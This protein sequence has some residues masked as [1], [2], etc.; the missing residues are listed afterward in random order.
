MSQ[1]KSE[2]ILSPNLST[3]NKAHASAMKL[4][5]TLI[6]LRK[7]IRDLDAAIRNISKN[8]IDAT[9]FFEH[10]KWFSKIPLKLSAELT[11]LIKPYFI[12]SINWNTETSTYKHPGSKKGHHPDTITYDV[13]TI[14]FKGILRNYT[15]NIPTDIYKNGKRP[16]SPYEAS[17]IIFDFFT[18]KNNPPNPTD[19]ELEQA[20]QELIKKIEKEKASLYKKEQ[21]LMKNKKEILHQLNKNIKQNL[22]NH[23]KG[24]SILEEKQKESIHYNPTGDEIVLDKDIFK[25][26]YLLV[27][28]KVAT[29]SS[30]KKWYTGLITKYD[31]STKKYTVEYDDGN[32]LN[33]DFTKTQF[34]ITDTTIIE[35]LNKL[36]RLE[37]EIDGCR[38]LVKSLSNKKVTN[39]STKKN[40]KYAFTDSPPHSSTKNTN[41][42]SLATDAPVPAM[43]V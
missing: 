13:V 26:P 34:I 40:K 10:F 18:H 28:I 25:Y 12:Y 1:S 29:Y 15:V 17:A 41:P 8:G 6:S 36:V 11:A 30:N 7:E 22:Q 16:I 5:G 2:L 43:E 4:N 19:T 35:L 24:V 38:I 33:K 14:I 31:V 9:Y 32:V 42:G 23:K 27:G 21:Q 37:R 20:K 39:N 3:Y